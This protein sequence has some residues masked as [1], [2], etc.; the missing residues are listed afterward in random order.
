MPKATSAATSRTPNASATDKGSSG[1]ILLNSF[2]TYFEPS[3]T[4]GMAIS[5]P[6]AA[7]LGL[8]E[9]LPQLRAGGMGAVHGARDTRLGAA[10][11]RWFGCIVC[12][13][14]ESRHRNHS[15]ELF[16]GSDDRQDNL[17]LPYP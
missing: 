12:N 14:P 10:L 17:P 2:S 8:H 4:T 6:N 5:I 1:F 11:A 13:Y 16:A 15:L 9:I 3:H 7:N